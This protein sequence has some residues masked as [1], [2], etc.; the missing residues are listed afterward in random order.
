MRESYR[1]RRL[2]P[3]AFR[4]RERRVGEDGSSAHWLHYVYT[5]RWRQHL[6]ILI[7][8]V[9]V[10][11]F[12]VPA[13]R[14]PGLAG[15]ATN[16]ALA[17]LQGEPARPEVRY[18][19]VGEGESLQTVA[20]QYG[21]TVETLRWANGL[22][23]LD[24][25]VVGQELLILPTDGVLHYLAAGE[26]ARQVA[27]YYAAEP[28]QV[29]A[30][31]AVDP[32]RPLR[33]A[34]LLVPGGRPRIGQ[35]VASVGIAG[36]SVD[37][38]SEVEQLPEGAQ[39]LQFAGRTLIVVEDRERREQAER[40]AATPAKTWE[41]IQQEAE[42]NTAAAVAASA[43]KP[44]APVEYEAQ[45]GDT[46]SGVAERYGVSSLTIVAANGLLDSDS[47]RVGQTLTIPPV[48]GVLYTVQ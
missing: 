6:A 46:I 9:L 29:A 28:D 24:P 17:W 23:D 3:N 41:E 27:L 7:A 15:A 11:P 4:P 1:S 13:A 45:P 16:P 19:Q 48:T 43:R 39:V 22:G 33:A 12:G 44:N 47:L 8:A 36:W 20:A 30:Y 21:L 18:H 40:T 35:A 38:L 10:I 31:N 34:Q 42:R 26:T 37:D 25:V 14:S 2:S 5:P 32:D